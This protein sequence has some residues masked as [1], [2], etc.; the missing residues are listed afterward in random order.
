MDIPAENQQIAQDGVA[1]RKA[2][3]LVWD[4]VRRYGATAVDIE[5]SSISVAY[6]FRSQDGRSG[7]GGVNARYASAISSALMESFRL[8]LGIDVVEVSGIGSGLFQLSLAKREEAPSVAPVLSLVKSNDS[9]EVCEGADNHD[10]QLARST[11]LVVEDNQTFAK[12]LLRFLT[13]QGFSVTM[14]GDGLEALRRLEAG[15]VPNLIMSDLHMPNLSGDELAIKV[16][17]IAALA[18][19]PLVLLTSDRSV[20]TELRALEAGVDL[21][22]SKSEDPRLIAA[23]AK[24]L[25][26]R[27]SASSV[28]TIERMEKL[29]AC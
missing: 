21:F 9:A 13:R 11:I 25:L 20:E 12:V 15:F 4:E 17:R 27:A 3:R 18:G 10:D 29:A 6:R 14:C 23:Y 7:E 28:H 16:R 1:A 19:T 8:T 26:S 5:I 2:I 22:L 24:R